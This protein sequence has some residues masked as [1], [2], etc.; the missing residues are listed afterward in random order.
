MPIKSDYLTVHGNVCVGLARKN[1][2]YLEEAQKFLE[3]SLS[4][5][6]Y[7][8]ETITQLAYCYISQGDYKASCDTIS[9]LA[10][11]QTF[12]PVT[13]VRISDIYETVEKYGEDTSDVD[14]IVYACNML[15]KNME[16]AYEMSNKHMARIEIAIK[17]RENFST[18]Q[19][20]LEKLDELGV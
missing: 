11:Y 19:R 9:K 5:N 3:R 15:V 4:L 6:K 20:I 13:Y 14:C 7:H 16:Y 1:P 8:Y 2:E 12:I 18:A 17:A 10:V